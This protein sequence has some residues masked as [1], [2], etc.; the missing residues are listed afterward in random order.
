MDVGV[1]TGQS[2]INSRKDVA[3]I[4]G[5]PAGLV[6]AIACAKHGFDT[7]L[8]AGSDT[9]EDGRTTALLAPSIALLQ[10]LGLWS[11]LA[12]Q[13]APLRSMRIIDDTGRLV[14]APEA[15]FHASELELEAFGFNV[16]NIDITSRL[17]TAAR[18]KNNLQILNSNARTVTFEADHAVV[19]IAREPDVV[20]DLVIGADG[21]NSMVRKAADI[22]TRSWRYDQVAIVCN[23]DHQAD[24][25]WMSTE[26]HTPTGPFTLVPLPGDG[27]QSSLVCV[28]KAAEAETML[29]LPRPDL[30]RDLERRAH[31]ILGHMTIASDP[32]VFPLGCQLAADFS[33]PQVA[34]IGEAAH[35]FPPIGAQGLNLGFRDAAALVETLVYARRDNKPIGAA[36]TLAPYNRSRNLD[37]WTRTAAV[38]ML[39]RTLLSDILPVQMA[40]GLGL[41]LSNRIGVLRRLLMRQSLAPMISGPRLTRGLP[42]G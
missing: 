8:V 29:A 21:R 30:N 31:S 36:S 16:T 1:M 23:L 42:L 39:N 6:A 40:R 32:Q 4:G 28:V 2:S 22:K 33:G 20:A 3:V 35:V 17:K 19:G 37:V 41:Y 27:R 15:V 24:H 7:V 34:L 11:G 14:R 18:H 13:A 12:E 9:V 38:D 25:H 10:Q 5:G 26:F